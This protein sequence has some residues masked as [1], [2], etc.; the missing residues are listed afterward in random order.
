KH[1]G[2]AALF[3]TYLGGSLESANDVALD[4]DTPANAYIA[5]ITGGNLPTTAGAFQ[6]VDHVSG[7]S[8]SDGFVAKISPVAVTVV[9][10]SPTSLNFGSV[11]L[12]TTS[13]TKT[14]T[15]FNLTASAITI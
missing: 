7:A 6:T 14:V 12:N 1:A 15:L 3:V 5:G 4:Q 8:N 2:S 13:P 9:F 11:A 10:A